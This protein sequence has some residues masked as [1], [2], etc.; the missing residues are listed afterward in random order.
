MSHRVW[1]PKRGKYVDAK[2]K[3]TAGSKQIWLDKEIGQEF[4]TDISESY[5]QRSESQSRGHS[6]MH[7]MTN[8][9]G[10]RTRKTSLVWNNNE[11]KRIDGDISVDD[12]VELMAAHFREVS[13]D[14]V[15]VEYDGDVKQIKISMNSGSKS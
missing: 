2:K 15:S 3:G 8:T 1:N 10:L 9:G 11:I 13:K 6:S 5:N 14:N 4:R 7:R 12:A